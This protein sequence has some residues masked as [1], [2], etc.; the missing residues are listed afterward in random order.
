VIIESLKSDK[1]LMLPKALDALAADK[2]NYSNITELDQFFINGRQTRCED[3]IVI[4]Q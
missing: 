4:C 3:T 1:A 2:R